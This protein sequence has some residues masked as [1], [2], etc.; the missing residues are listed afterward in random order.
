MAIAYEPG[1][2]IKLNVPEC[3]RQFWTKA[4]SWKDQKALIARIDAL[5]QL[6]TE[7]QQTDEALSILSQELMRA[8]PDV[9]MDSDSLSSVLDYRAIWKLLAAVKF[10]LTFEEKKSSE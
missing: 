10:N 3:T 7:E 4:K 5:K 8:D 9:D 6:E 1:D 2:E